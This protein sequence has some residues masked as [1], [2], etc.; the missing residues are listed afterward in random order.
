[1]ICPAEMQLSSGPL[2]AISYPR[3]RIKSCQEDLEVM[4]KVGPQILLFYLSW[5]A[6][7]LYGS[8][9]IVLNR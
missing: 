1:M 7:D 3:V 8:I 2:A 6:R 4:C 5:M 9:P